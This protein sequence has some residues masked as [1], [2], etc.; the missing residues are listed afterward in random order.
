METL[1][2]EPFKLHQVSIDDLE[3]R[4]G[5]DFSAYAASDA[6]VHPQ[7]TARRLLPAREAVGVARGAREIRSAEQL[8]F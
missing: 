5:L 7:R 8:A 6:L 1:D 2:L 3:G 4:T